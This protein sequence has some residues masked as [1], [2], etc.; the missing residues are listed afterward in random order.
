MVIV[1][2]F[3]SSNNTIKGVKKGSYKSR[4]YLRSL[5]LTHDSYLKSTKEL[6]W[7]DKRK[8]IQPTNGHKTWTSTSD[9]GLPWWRSGEESTCQLRRH[10][11]HPW[12]WKIPHAAEHRAPC[13][14]TTAPASCNYQSP[15]PQSPRPAAREALAVRSPRSPVRRRP[16]SPQLEKTH[17]RAAKTRSSQK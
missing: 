9:P 10:S 1:E 3:F 17:S 4:R 12:S 2:N 5:N 16:R 6:L 15:R 11:F 7:A 14:A 13:I 8:T